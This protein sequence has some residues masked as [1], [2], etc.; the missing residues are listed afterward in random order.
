MLPHWGSRICKFSSEVP[1]PS[2]TRVLISG[3]LLNEEAELMQFDNVRLV[4]FL[5][6]VDFH[7]VFYFVSA[8]VLFFFVRF[9]LVAL[10]RISFIKLY[11][12]YLLTDLICHFLF[13]Y[14]IIYNN[15]QITLL[16]LKR[17][18]QCLKTLQTQI[19][20]F[21]EKVNK[22]WYLLRWNAKR[23]EHLSCSLYSCL[24]RSVPSSINMLKIA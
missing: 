18:D 17:N 23:A 3:S 20:K 5:I 9:C 10:F 2:T 15:V 13:F 6:V 11:W 7:F 14:Y 8:F 24:V 12:L 4:F 22:L 1:L 16:M 19:E 21:L